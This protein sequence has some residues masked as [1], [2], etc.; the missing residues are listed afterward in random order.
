M[1]HINS[2]LLDTLDPLQFAYRP[3]RSTDDTISIALHTALSHLDKRNT[4]VRMLFIDYSSVF[5]T[6]LPTKLITKL[7]TLGLNTSLCNWI[8]PPGGKSRHQNVCHGNP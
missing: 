2:I 1:A 6:I 7:R 8:Q 3:N 4:Y 5:T